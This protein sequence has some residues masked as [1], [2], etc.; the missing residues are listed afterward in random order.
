MA[1]LYCGVTLRE[2]VEDADSENFMTLD[3]LVAQ[4]KFPKDEQGRRAPGAHS[5]DNLM[6]C[7]YSCNHAKGNSVVSAFCRDME[8]KPSTIRNRIHARRQRNV[9][10]EVYRAMARMALGEI[11]GFPRAHL[12]RDHDDLARLQWANQLDR[13]IWGLMQ[14]ERLQ[15]ALFCESCGTPKQREEEVPF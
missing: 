14:E 1:C 2:L 12:V 3:H 8:L 15:E 7:C 11:P 10:F 9:R 5:T 6:A 4:S 13:D